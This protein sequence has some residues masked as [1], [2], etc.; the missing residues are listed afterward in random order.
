MRRLMDRF[1]N[2]VLDSEW[3]QKC[4]CPTGGDLA[5]VV[6]PKRWRKQRKKGNRN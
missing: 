4:Q 6:V 1:Y 2:P 5:K 3:H